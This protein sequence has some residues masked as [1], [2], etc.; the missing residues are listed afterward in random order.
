[1][2]AEK[3]WERTVKA[4]YSSW[5]EM[6]SLAITNPSIETIHLLAEKGH[7]GRTQLTRKIQAVRWAIK[8]DGLTPAGVVEVGQRVIMSRYLK[9]MANGKESRMNV[10][11][12][13][14][15][16]QK[17]ILQMQI[18]RIK[19]LLRSKDNP[20]T[21]EEF[22]DWLASHLEQLSDNEIRNHAMGV[23]S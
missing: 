9:A 7:V 8:N 1:M 17:P 20:A 10:T 19:E 22:T 14:R 12:G 5:Q 6:V 15:E 23:G 18:E 13:V 3:Q 4:I 16:S 21:T 11:L 2:S